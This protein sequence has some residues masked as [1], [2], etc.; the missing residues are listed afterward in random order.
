MPFESSESSSSR[1]DSSRRTSTSRP[2]PG[3]F[4]GRDWSSHSATVSLLGATWKPCL[5]ASWPPPSPSRK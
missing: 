5:P 3:A 2:T 1:K 4:A